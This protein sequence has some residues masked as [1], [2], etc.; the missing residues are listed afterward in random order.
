MLTDEQDSS[1]K[2]AMN[3]TQQNGNTEMRTGEQAS[4]WEKAMNSIQQ[5]G[6]KEML[7]D[8]QVSSWRKQRTQ[9]NGMEGRKCSRTNKLLAEGKH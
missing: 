2:K 9:F 4:S 5:N 7:T 6:R 3:S 8:E 1:W